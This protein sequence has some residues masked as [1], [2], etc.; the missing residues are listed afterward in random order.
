MSE[1]L[2]IDDKKQMAQTWFRE[3]RDQIC[4]RFEALESSYIKETQSA[5][6]A[7]LEPLSREPIPQMVSTSAPPLLRAGS[8][9]Q[10]TMQISP[11]TIHP[12][13]FTQT[14]WNRPEGGGGVMSIMKGEVFEKV[15]VN[16]STVH[17]EFSDTFRKEMPLVNDDPR[18][19]ATG[20]SLVA[21][22]KN[23][24]VPNVHMNTRMIITGDGD[25]ARIW[26][27]GGGDLNPV[28]P[29]AEETEFF[30]A[31]YKR[32]CD[33]TDAGYYEKFHAWC[34]EYFWLKHRNCA[35]G[36]GGIFYDYLD[37]DWQ[38]H[39]DFTQAVGRAFLEAFPP[40][41]ERNMHKPYTD[42][43]RHAQLVYRGRYAEFN[44]LYDRGTRFGLMTGGNTDAILMSLPPV[45]VWV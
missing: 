16:I 21:H 27:G 15:G 18:F 20:I 31:A 22:M 6:P 8:A 44:L 34:E 32:A 36:V 3:L 33:A 29:V 35:R 43:E 23:P 42:S 17:G 11:F 1:S 41:I 9:K 2:S 26:F 19:W 39:F 37:T 45:A 30:H 7:S 38:K 14:T 13:H 5:D 24:H 25:N 10:E 4:A 28:F 12:P 40:L